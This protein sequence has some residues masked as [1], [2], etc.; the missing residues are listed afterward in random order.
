MATE[1]KMTLSERIKAIFGGKA[2]KIKSLEAKNES[3][4]KELEAMGK[5]RDALQKELLDVE[6]SLEMY[7]Q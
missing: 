3:L 6:Q 5:K 7:E 2:E 1:K 4:K